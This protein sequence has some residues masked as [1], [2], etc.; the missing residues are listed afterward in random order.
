MNKIKISEY[1]MLVEE[2]IR[3]YILENFLFSDVISLIEYDDSFREK[4]IIDSTG[5][6]EVVH[7]L[8]EEFELRIWR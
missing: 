2:K 1:E 4:G 5:I 8:E 7:S 6:Q 3:N